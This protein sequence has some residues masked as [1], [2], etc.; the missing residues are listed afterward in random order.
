MG[1]AAP[2]SLSPPLAGEILRFA[3]G[4]HLEASLRS[5]GS[6]LT[7]RRAWP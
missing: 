3:L 1:S 2:E 5:E 4:E 7:D 6:R